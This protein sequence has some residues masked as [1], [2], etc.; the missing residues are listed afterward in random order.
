MSINGSVV[1]T[2]VI[3]LICIVAAGALILTRWRPA[4][5]I[6]LPRINFRG[7][8]G[9]GG[10]H[11]PAAAAHAP[12]AHGHG[13]HAPSP[14]NWGMV[15]VLLGLA[16]LL[17]AIGILSGRSP[18]VESIGTVVKN[19]WFWIL[20]S[21][22]VLF[23]TASLMPS[24]KGTAYTLLAVIGFLL[25]L[26]AGSTVQVAVSDTQSEHAA[27]QTEPPMSDASTMGLH[28]QG[29]GVPLK[30]LVPGEAITVY[31][32]DFKGIENFPN[33]RSGLISLCSFSDETLCASPDNPLKLSSELRAVKNISD[34]NIKYS[35]TYHPS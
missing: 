5:G 31:L 27:Q 25:L 13:G 12:A 14:G 8:F 21:F 6:R 34:H 28:C 11:A 18:S 22:I 29:E 9:G 23:V 26:A 24:G 10:G 17:A 15:A 4:R 19:G 20:L 35:C 30:E 1:G 2:V 7:M 16:I 32:P 3:V 33:V